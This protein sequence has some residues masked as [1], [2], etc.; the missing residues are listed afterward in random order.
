[1]A[2]L[3]VSLFVFFMHDSYF[4]NMIQI[5]DKKFIPYITEQ[6]LQTAVEAMAIK[7]AR[8]YVGKPLYLLGVLN[9][10]FRFIADLVRHIH[11]P[12]EIGFARLSSYEGTQT[13]GKVHNLMNLPTN[14]A[15][16]HV[17]VVEDIVDTGLTLQYLMPEITQTG[18]TSSKIATL[19]FKSVNLRV[20]LTVDYAGFE[21]PDAFVVGYGLD[22]NGLGRELNEIYQVHE[23]D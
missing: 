13:T 7:I 12:V 21:I 22:Y 16:K 1:M 18:A 2:F 8:D 14:M 9:G 11:L 15:G 17:I 6:A 5:H 19:L 20:P 3:Y 23:N 10:S 4:Y